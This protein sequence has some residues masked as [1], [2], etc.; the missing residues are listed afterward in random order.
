MLKKQI[1]IPFISIGCLL[2]T[3]CGITPNVDLQD[4]FWSNAHQ[5]VAVAHSKTIVPDLYHRGQEGLLDIAINSVVNDKFTHQVKQSDMSWYPKL[6]QEFVAHLHKNKIQAKAI[7]EPLDESRLPAHPGDNKSIARKDYTT[8]TAT[9]DSDK[10]LVIYVNSAG[11]TRQFSGFIPLGKPKAI[12]SLSGRLIDLKTNAILWQHT[13]AV[14]IDIAD[15]WDEAPNYHNFTTA[16]KTAV[17]FAQKE[18]EDSFFS[19]G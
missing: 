18:L 14:E 1:L 6:Q 9:I 11:A 13:A 12:C 8:L 10:L 15:P 7:A 3:A 19:R 16:F 17:S 5:K 2:L 4:S